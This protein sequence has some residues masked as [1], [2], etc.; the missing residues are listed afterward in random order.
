MLGNSA[1]NVRQPTQQK[2]ICQAVWMEYKASQECFAQ[3]RQDTARGAGNR[4]G[5]HVSQDTFE[6]CKSL[7]EPAP[8]R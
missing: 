4:S 7:P 1:L 8:C 3:H 6:Q 5:S 2:E